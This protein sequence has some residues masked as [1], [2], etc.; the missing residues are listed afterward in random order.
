MA[1]KEDK[2]RK[3][4]PK[5][6]RF[7]GEDN[8]K[9]PLVSERGDSD[10]YFE[11]RKNRSDKNLT[12][13]L[14]NGGETDAED[15]SRGIVRKQKSKKLEEGGSVEELQNQIE[16]LEEERDNFQTEKEECEEEK[17]ELQDKID[18]VRDDLRY[19]QGGNIDKDIKAKPKGYRFTGDNYKRP[20]VSE[21]GDSDVYFEARKNRSDKN[22]TKKLA[23]GGNLEHKLDEKVLTIADAMNDYE[24][25]QD[26]VQWLRDWYYGAQSEGATWEHAYTIAD[27][28]EN[29]E[30][31][32][33]ELNE[34]YKPYAKELRE[35]INKW[36]IVNELIKK[37][38]A[39][40]MAKG[41]STQEKY[42][43]WVG[44]GEV[45]D[46]ALTKEEA[47][48]LANEY[49]EKGYDDVVIEQFGKG[50]KIASKG[51]FDVL[52]ETRSFVELFK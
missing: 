9:R 18:R 27:K 12:K 10:V 24:D 48:T 28:L 52:N 32:R 1:K 50:G 6:Y 41:G 38:E 21:R 42:T 35:L 49:K 7:K 4:K 29:H 51:F 33:S 23:K 20:L 22:L 13:K 36:A 3:A 19:K 30:K 39:I 8:N 44:G 46:H 14:E 40:T 31:N 2:E 15:L 11:S 34:E 37:E 25:M 5:G 47:E 43:V 45:N 16:E 26:D 17:Q